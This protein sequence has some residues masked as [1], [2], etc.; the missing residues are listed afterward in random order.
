MDK[1]TAIITIVFLI[2]IFLLYILT[3]IIKLK[4]KKNILSTI[5]K[6][7]TEKNLIISASLITEIS[8]AGKL[9]NNK[10]MERDV[11]NWKTWCAPGIQLA[12][13]NV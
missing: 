13:G 4:K 11:E 8:K 7:T 6:L 2:L 1:L 5:D 10:K 9:V 3:I 12:V